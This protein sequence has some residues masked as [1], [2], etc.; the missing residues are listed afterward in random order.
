[1]G[2]ALNETVVAEAIQGSLVSMNEH[3]S[4]LEPANITDAVFANGRIIAH[5]VKQLAAA[6]HSNRVADAL[7]EL[8]KLV[9]R[10]ADAVA[11]AAATGYDSTGERP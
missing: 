2:R 1:M 8:A 7:A 4:N 3:D 11:A 9:G 5:A 6:D 10:V